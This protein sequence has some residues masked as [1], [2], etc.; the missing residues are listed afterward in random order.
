[1]PTK[2]NQ[3]GG[4][5]SAEAAAVARVEIG[6]VQEAFKLTELQATTL[7]YL[8][9]RTGPSVAEALSILYNETSVRLLSVRRLRGPLLER[10]EVGHRIHYAWDI[11]CSSPHATGGDQV[12]TLG[13]TC[14]S[15][16]LQLPP[17]VKALISGLGRWAQR[18]EDKALPHMLGEY[19][20]QFRRAGVPDA[21]IGSRIIAEYRATP[22]YAEVLCGIKMIKGRELEAAQ[23]AANQRR[24]DFNV[25]RL[26]HAIKTCEVCDEGDLPFAPMLVTRIRRAVRRLA[27]VDKRP[28]P[29]APQQTAANQPPPAVVTYVPAAPVG[30]SGAPVTNTNQLH[31][32]TAGG[33]AQLELLFI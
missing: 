30:T 10:C 23:P 2:T 15:H 32:P 3:P 7:Y 11:L 22:V 33:A 5:V 14:A 12:H 8:L 26:C 4:T 16:V 20:E 9:A 6:K 1:M 28:L 13:S 21:Q 31:V 18:L 24:R 19:V 27:E 17:A 25:A 29:S